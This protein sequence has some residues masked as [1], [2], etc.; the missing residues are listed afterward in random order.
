MS[1]YATGKQKRHTWHIKAV[2]VC[3][4][5][6]AVHVC[7]A[8]LKNNNTVLRERKGEERDSVSQ[9]NPDAC[10]DRQR[11]K[12]PK[13]LREGNKEIENANVNI[14]ILIV[15]T[16]VLNSTCPLIPHGVAALSAF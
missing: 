4:F 2:P 5:G 13:T 9:H 11:L 12:R 8:H 16:S 14:L 1:V 7:G 6:I 3:M 15:Y 10:D